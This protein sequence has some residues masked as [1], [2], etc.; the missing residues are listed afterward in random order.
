MGSMVVLLLPGLPGGGTDL[1][2]RAEYVGNHELSW[3]LGW[4]PWQLTSF[5]DLLLVVALVCTRWIPKLPATVALILTAVALWF[6]QPA[7]FRWLTKGVGLAHDAV[8]TANTGVYGKFEAETFRMTSLWAALFYTLAAI[9]MSVA[10]ARAGTWSRFMTALS[11]AVWTLLLAVSAVPLKWPAFPAVRISGGNAV[12]FCLMIAWFV[13]SAELVLRR[14]R[15]FTTYGIHANWRSPYSSSVG[16]IIDLIAN[17]R[18]LRAFGELPPVLA[19]A[20][21]ISDVVYMN[22]VVPAVAVRPLIP[23]YLELR[24]LGADD[25]L[26]VVTVLIFQHG[27]FGP[28]IIGPFRRFLP[29]PVQSNW[30]CHVV[31]PQT[32]VIGICFFHTTISNPI[33]ALLTRVFAE[34]LPMHLPKKS[35][36]R[37]SGSGAVAI[38]VEPGHGSAG[39]IYAELSPVT[40][41]SLSKPFM[42]AFG[43]PQAMLE[44]IV[45]QD[46]ALIAV[47]WNR[48]VC[49]LE[50]ELGISPADCEPLA[51]I[52]KSAALGQI[53]GAI[54]NEAE[55]VCFR[56][57]KLKFQFG[58]QINVRRK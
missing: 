5:S 35:E 38:G 21:E 17:S 13:V 47:P 16:T 10:L 53:L 18:L 12:G 31:D 54:V 9:G 45:P 58:R 22:Y 29:S 30:R 50:I 41:W 32:G 15:P 43:T 1:L 37:R 20:S 4:L 42:S 56:I 49:Q 8:R 36:L 2:H 40:D 34:G 52:V 19:Y 51:G 25:D 6:E 23:A 39:D 46:R 24:T 28:S 44:Y 14:A 48:R 55:P 57:P 7:E 11:V 27:S 26:A 3:R 33:N